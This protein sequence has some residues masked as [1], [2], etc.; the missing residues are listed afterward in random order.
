M[1]RSA[2]TVLYDPDQP[3]NRVTLSDPTCTT[4]KLRAPHRNGTECRRCYD[5]RRLWGHQRPATLDQAEQLRLGRRQTEQRLAS[6]IDPRW[7]EL[8]VA[9]NPRRR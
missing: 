5:Y 9:A 3:G 6:R 4:C 2:H 7:H 8:T 1:T